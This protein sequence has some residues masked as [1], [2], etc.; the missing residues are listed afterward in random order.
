MV[1]KHCRSTMESI[2]EISLRH[3]FQKLAAKRAQF[4]MELSQQMNIM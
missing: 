1:A 3:Y 2:S 4:A